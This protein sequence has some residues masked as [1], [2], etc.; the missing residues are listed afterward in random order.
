MIAADARLSL[1]GWSANCEVADQVELQTG[2]EP[3]RNLLAYPELR[4]ELDDTRRS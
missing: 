1:T 2:A 3:R 4:G